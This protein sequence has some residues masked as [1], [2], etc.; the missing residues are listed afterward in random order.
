[1]A[2]AGIILDFTLLF[3]AILLI[4]GLSGYISERAGI[5]NIGIDGMM[6]FGAVMFAVFSSPVLKI[7]T[8][9]TWSMPIALILTMVTTMFIGMLHAF[10]CIN[11]KSNHIISGTAINLAG[12]AFATFVNNPLAVLL[13]NHNPRLETGYHQFWYL[14]DA[15]IY[16]GSLFIFILTVVL[17]VIIWVVMNKTKTGLRYRAVGENPFAVDAQGI[18]VLKYQWNAVLLSSALAGLAGALFLYKIQ[19]FQGNTQG[20]GYLALA[21]MIVGAWR[22]Q[23]ISV[24]SWIFAVVT[25]L[26]SSNVLT[27]MGTPKA[28]AYSI[29]YVAT[30][31]ILVFFSRWVKAPEHDG[32]PFDRTL[33]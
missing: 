3:G 23:W 19:Y 11:L 28:I 13:Y 27:N 22:V 9:G 32:I 5:V 6:C 33:R 25:A 7:S 14:Q 21:I 20:F 1:M 18:S 24:A 30:I 29:P 16:G 2:L 4:G 31:V 26:A 17:V 12:L 15:H 8:L 10:S